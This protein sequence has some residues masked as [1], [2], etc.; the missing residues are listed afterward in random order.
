LDQG[1][2]STQVR[3]VE[4]NQL[5][6]SVVIMPGHTRL[7]SQRKPRKP[8]RPL[9]RVPDYVRYTGGGRRYWRLGGPLTRDH[10]TAAKAAQAAKRPSRLGRLVLRVLGGEDSS[11]AVIR[12]GPRRCP[13]GAVQRWRPAREY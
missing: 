7:V 3:R 2:G 1:D 10:E 9:P 12:R 8:K 11:P 6:H 13:T 5:L 4:L